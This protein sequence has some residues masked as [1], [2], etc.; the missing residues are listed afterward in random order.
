MRKERPREKEKIKIKPN[1]VVLGEVIAN[2]PSEKLKRVG[3]KHNDARKIRSKST[4]VLHGKG[5]ERG[6]R[7]REARS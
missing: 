7:S 2:Q 5:W 1:W 3:Q 4:S 6:V